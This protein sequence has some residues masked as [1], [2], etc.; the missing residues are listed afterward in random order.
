MTRLDGL[1]FGLGGALSTFPGV[2]CVGSAV[3]I[4]SV[5][6]METDHALNLALIMNIPVNLGFI[7]YDVL[8]IFTV[9]VSGFSLTVLL[10]SVLAAGAVFAGIIFGI[11]LLKKI[12]ERFGYGVFALYS[13]G[14]ALLAFMI[15]LMVV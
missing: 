14:A 1:I 7:L 13:W 9:G 10:G 15:Y 12:T 5:R 11:H 4:G 3:S 6:G 8:E 2:S